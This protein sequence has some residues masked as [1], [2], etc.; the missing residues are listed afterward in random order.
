MI[1]EGSALV[2]HK[3]NNLRD[4]QQS[5]SLVA[6]LEPLHNTYISDYGFSSVNW[7]S[8]TVEALLQY[9][10]NRYNILE[11]GS[12]NI[13]EIG[14]TYCSE[15]SDVC[16]ICSHDYSVHKCGSEPFYDTR[17]V[18]IDCVSASASQAKA[19]LSQAPPSDIGVVGPMV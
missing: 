4:I 15:D 18:V 2:R 8:S 14:S 10:L 5:R 9:Q 13:L 17:L 6:L 3:Y 19:A 11:N 16:S 12:N 1:T 7:I